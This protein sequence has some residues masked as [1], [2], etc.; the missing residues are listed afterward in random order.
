MFT[1]RLRLVLVAGVLVL[2]ALGSY[3]IAAHAFSTN[4]F[5]SFPLDDPWI[6][7]QFAKN[8]HDYGSFSYYKNEMVTAGSTS[9]LYTF[10]LALG[11]FLTDNEMVLSY[12]LGV[13]LLLVAAVYMFKI[14]ERLFAARSQTIVA[15][16]AP[17]LLL[18]EMRMQWAALSGME[19]TLFM[20]LLLAVMYSY[21]MQK[22]VHLGV[23]SGLLLW[24][25]PEA[26]IMFIAV[27]LDVVYHGLWVGSSTHKAKTK[28]TSLQRRLDLSWL[29][30]STIILAALTML[31]ALFNLLL[32]GSLFP[33]TFS[34]KLKYYGIGGKTLFPSQV[35]H[36]LTDGHMMVI[37]LGIA[38]GLVSMVVD[39]LKR[40][41][42]P[43]LAVVL[44]SVGMFVAYWWKLPYL[45]QEGRY[46]MPVVPF[47]VLVGLDGL[48][49]A[50][51][52]IA[53][54]VQIAG[55]RT[56]WV[57][58]GVV[59]TVLI[60]QFALATWGKRAEY[61][62]MC[63]YIHDRQVRTALWLRDN[64]PPSAVIGTHDIGAM[65]FYS[66]RR[67]ADMV[68]LVSPEMIERIGSLERLRQFLVEKK[69][70]HLALLRNWFEVVNQTPLYKT[71]EREPEIMEVFAFDP[72]TTHITSQDVTRAVEVAAQYLYQGQ[73]QIASDILQ[74]ALQVDPQNSKVHHLIG[75]VYLTSG[76]TA[77][78]RASFE[79]A[80][81]LYPD[82]LE[83]QIGLAQ[84]LARENKVEEAVE[85]L[86]TLAHQRPDSPIVYR[87]L[88]DVYRYFKG[89]S[90]QA[91]AYMERFHQLIQMQQT[92]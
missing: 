69:V 58:H 36:F 16:S 5:F 75:M 31:Y 79:T 9:P 8:L 3:L 17:I 83:A 86:Q 87:A 19:T 70:T 23:A 78:A 24:A 81:R 25:R 35:F 88:A 43:L 67:I 60:V 39:L 38:I 77:A 59:I 15:F 44:F 74:R 51:E 89:D 62:F 40:R 92:Q 91:Q 2:G 50:T 30:R 22:P 1:D 10:L 73:G 53:A 48:V 90:T 45:Y 84:V 61:A 42:L 21:T 55:K 68:G 18:L 85:R 12:V 66:G 64:T 33:N 54:L 6:H 37:A 76:R 11:F 13:A 20:A 82:F 28:H 34:A 32:S 57:L 56:A 46:M 65:A 14:A 4:G 49:R 63:R 7:L 47:F 52:K 71:N 80:L 26:V 41:P 29:K 27:A 72:H